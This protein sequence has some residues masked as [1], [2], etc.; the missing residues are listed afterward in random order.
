MV[1]GGSVRITPS[2]VP[3]TTT[4]DIRWDDAGLTGARPTDKWWGDLAL[5]AATLTNEGVWEWDKAAQRLE[6]WVPNPADPMIRRFVAVLEGFAF[7]MAPGSVGSGH[8]VAGIVP[9]VGNPPLT[10]QGF[11]GG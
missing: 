11:P 5:L 9:A 1:H 8:L 2:W 6:L 3:A 4:I 10:W 7:P